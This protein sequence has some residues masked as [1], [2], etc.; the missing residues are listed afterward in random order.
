M[1]SSS[2]LLLFKRRRDVDLAGN[3][4][5]NLHFMAG[6]NSVGEN[7]CGKS[8]VFGPDGEPRAVVSTDEEKFSSAKL[9]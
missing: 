7:A 8:Q 9:I 2:S 5:F 6:T 1:Q 3:G 4:L